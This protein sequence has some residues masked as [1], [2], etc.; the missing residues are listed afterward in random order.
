VK[1]PSF[2]NKS[3]LTLELLEQKEE[4]VGK[5]AKLLCKEMEWKAKNSISPHESYGMAIAYTYHRYSTFSSI[6]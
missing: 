2:L 1:E 3:P 5:K 4:E 6:S